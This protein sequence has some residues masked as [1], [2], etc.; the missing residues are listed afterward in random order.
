[1]SK[2]TNI[3]RSLQEKS[4]T[5]KMNWFY[6]IKFIYGNKGYLMI[7]NEKDKG[8]L[9]LKGCEYAYIDQIPYDGPHCWINDIQDSLAEALDGWA[10]L[11]FNSP[12][13]Y[14]EDETIIETHFNELMI[15]YNEDINQL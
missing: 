1:M 2:N 9:E 3:H 15:G 12:C 13:F 10:I 14:E 7:T 8:W 5:S 6:L 11:D 4:L